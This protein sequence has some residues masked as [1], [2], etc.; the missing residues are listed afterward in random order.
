[1]LRL[2][3]YAN[4]YQYSKKSKW[5]V[6]KILFSKC[7]NVHILNGHMEFMVMIIE[8]KLEKLWFGK[9]IWYQFSTDTAL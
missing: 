4:R 5:I 8:S 2:E 6:L 7:L 9:I 3:R 1:M